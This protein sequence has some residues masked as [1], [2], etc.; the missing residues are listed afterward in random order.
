LNLR[1]L[2]AGA[3]DNDIRFTNAPGDSDG[4]YDTLQFAF[5]RRF[6]GNFFL[7]A[8]LDYQWRKEM[9]IPEFETTSPLAADPITTWYYPEYNRNISLSQSSKNWNFNL[10]ARYV[11]PYDVGIAGTW[12]HQ[13]G[14]PWAP[15]HVLA[16]PNV[17][18][19]NVFLEDI[20]NNRSENVNIVDFRLDKA[21]SMGRSTR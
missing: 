15:I 18:T 4:N 12:R 3:E 19:V 10:A 2:P 14:F 20:E 21:F 6:R 1:T 16:L 5:K 7:N 9:R 17:G 11:L 8:N 13:S